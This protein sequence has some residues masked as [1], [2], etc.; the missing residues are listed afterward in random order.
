[1]LK[2]GSN[3]DDSTDLHNLCRT[4]NFEKVKEYVQSMNG[5]TLS[6]RLSNKKGVFG[7]TPLHEAVSNG[8]NEI[9]EYLLNRRIE[10]PRYQISPVNCKANSGYTALHLAAG[11]GHMDCVKTLIKHN[12]DISILDVYKK[13]PKETARMNSKSAITLLL[14]GEG[15]YNIPP[16]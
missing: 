2:N 14:H 1:M 10:T 3:S 5:R 9:L 15:T 13:T 12:A 4:G 16:L 8:N 7:F 11:N 6:D